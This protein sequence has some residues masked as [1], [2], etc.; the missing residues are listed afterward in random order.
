MDQ[1]VPPSGFDP[2]QPSPQDLLWGYRQGLFPMGS[3][4][5]GGLDW[6]CPD[7][8]AI[9]DL[10]AFHVPRS[11]ARRVRSKRFEICFDR[12]FEAVLDACSRLDDQKEEGNWIT[13]AIRAAY[14]RLHQQGHAHSVEAYRGGALVGGLYGVRIGA[15][16]FGESMFSDPGRGG[17]DASKVALVHLVE[18]LRVAE[19]L[20]LDVQF[21]TPHL[22]Q[23]GC[24]ELPREVYLEQL[25]IAVE[26]QCGP[27]GAVNL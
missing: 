24:Q 7:P 22:E 11:L 16:F 21:H 26:Q 23:F 25:A 3:P 14:L 8:R 18:Q 15:A 20:L 9:L 19:F 27:L 10:S 12:D 1:L 5:H 4:E 6:Y 17:R 13:P 2:D